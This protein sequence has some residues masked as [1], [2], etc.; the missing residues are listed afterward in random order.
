[1]AIQQL[2]ADYLIVGA[3]AVG[4]AFADT[5][6]GESDA[7]IIIVDR[8][9]K[10]GGH[11][12]VAYPFVQLHQPSQFYGVSSK[13]L[14]GGRI[15]R[16]GLNDGLNELAS[17]AEVSAYFD[18]VMRHQFLPSGRVQFFPMCDYK[19]EGRFE[20][21]VGNQRYQVEVGK[22][23]VD[24][25]FLKTKV[26][27][28][29]TPN[30]SIAD[31]VP[32]MPLNDL[33]KVTTPP[34]HYMVIG[35]GKTG[36]DA[37]LWL[38]GMGV[39]PDC[40]DWVRPRDSWLLNRKNA[41]PTDD[42][43]YNVFGAQLALMESAAKAASYE[44]LFERLEAGGYFLRLDQEVT[45]RMFHGATISEPELK[46]LQTIRSVIRLGRITHLGDKTIEFQQGSLPAKPNTIYV[47]CSARPL[48]GLP[49]D[50][51]VFNGDTITPQMVRSYQPVFSAALIAHIEL[52]MDDDEAKNS[53]TTP[54]PPPEADTDF[55][56][57][58]AVSMMNQYLWSQNDDIAEWLLGNR[59]DGFSRMLKNAKEDPEKT[60]LLERMRSYG[61]DAVSNLFKLHNDFHAQDAA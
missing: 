30:F 50:V 10:P 37:C 16:G 43:F 23:I 28:T 59:L 47:D 5:I 49:D 41:Q 33:P 31:G 13:E 51:P 57:F 60:Q 24:A 38:L 58:S 14:S 52:S 61:P 39:D 56:Y 9:A 8:Y 55:A 53:V 34:D 46:L 48:D 2:R 12:N 11:W 6:L 7:S 45:P 42:F 3:G 27:S 40:I 22:K 15:E 26:P 54:V 20:S 25:T 29:H 4:M 17:G 18:D 35:G 44:D 21:I 36:I 1:M 19:G 32:F